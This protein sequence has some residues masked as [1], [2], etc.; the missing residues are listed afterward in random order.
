[1]TTFTRTAGLFASP[2]QLIIASDIF[3]TGKVDRVSLKKRYEQAFNRQSSRELDIVDDKRRKALNILALNLNLPTSALSKNSEKS[4]FQLGGE[5]MTMKQI[6]LFIPLGPV[7]CPSGTK[8]CKSTFCFPPKLTLGLNR[9][10][11]FFFF[12][13]CLTSGSFTPMPSQISVR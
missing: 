13:I 1:M 4:F 2:G 3:Y 6:I 8:F 11:S 7:G 5:F 12:W 9:S 10:N